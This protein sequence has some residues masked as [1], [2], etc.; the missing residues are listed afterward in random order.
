VES[1]K[2][3]EAEEDAERKRRGRALRRVV[4]VQEG[5]QPSPDQAARQV[6]HRKWVYPVG[7]AASVASAPE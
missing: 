4:D 2:R 3:R 6:N 5:V 7:R 1:E